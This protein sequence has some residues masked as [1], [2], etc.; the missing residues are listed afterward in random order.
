M[1]PARVSYIAQEILRLEA[2]EQR[3]DMG[4]TRRTE[5]VT[6]LKALRWA[7][8]VLLTGRPTEPPGAEVE[9]FL[10]ALRGQEG[11]TDDDR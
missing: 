11:A 5:V 3:T 4:R 6:R 7:L 8:H 1:N 2:E 9:A 10:G